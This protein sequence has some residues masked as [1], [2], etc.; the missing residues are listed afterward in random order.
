MGAQVYP[1]A[2]ETCLRKDGR[3]LPKEW[4]N[5]KAA[6]GKTHAY[7]TTTR[8]LRS[9]NIDDTDY[10]MGKGILDCVAKAVVFLCVCLSLLGGGGLLDDD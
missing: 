4:Q 6:R 8:E 1:D 2:E 7:V 5:D 10:L 3:N 9:V